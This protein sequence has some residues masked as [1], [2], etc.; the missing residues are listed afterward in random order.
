MYFEKRL[1]LCKYT[2]AVWTNNRLHC[3]CIN[4]IQIPN[5]G[6]W[7]QLGRKSH[8]VDG[9]RSRFTVTGGKCSGV[10]VVLATKKGVPLP[11]AGTDMLDSVVAVLTG[12]DTDMLSGDAVSL[13]LLV[14]L[15]HT[16]K[17]FLLNNNA[18]F[19]LYHNKRACLYVFMLDSWFHRGS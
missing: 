8:A 17:L 15:E 7:Q 18:K 4:F 19:C 1:V 11:A 6:K 3:R 14:E 10:I 13:K 16:P 9:R 5:V 2:N 12:E